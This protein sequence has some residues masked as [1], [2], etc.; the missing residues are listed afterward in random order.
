[1]EQSENRRR[2]TAGV[3]RS[4]DVGAEQSACDRQQWRPL[5]KQMIVTD[6]SKHAL[7]HE[8]ANGSDLFLDTRTTRT[9]RSSR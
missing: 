3:Q 1:M 6:E 9:A 8:L 2:R 7:E 5:L 4:L